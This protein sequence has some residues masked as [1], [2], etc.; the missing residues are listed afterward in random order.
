[1]IRMAMRALHFFSLNHKH[2][3]LAS[4]LSPQCLDAF[5]TAE[6]STMLDVESFFFLLALEC[7]EAE[8]AKATEASP[9]LGRC[10]DSSV[11]WA[12]NQHSAGWYN[13]PQLK[14]CVC[15]RAAFHDTVCSSGKI[16]LLWSCDYLCV[17]FL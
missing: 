1:M 2:R 8:K 11:L 9:S 14:K 13:P 5:H 16:S 3:V 4:H 15:Q 10:R 17:C 7:T 6:E 12:H